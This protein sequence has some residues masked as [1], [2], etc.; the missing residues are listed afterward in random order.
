ML[1]PPIEEPNV[2]D[3]AV[4]KPLVLPSRVTGFLVFMFRVFL[5]PLVLSLTWISPVTLVRLPDRVIVLLLPWTFC[6]A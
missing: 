6:V 1:V 5:L 3:T 4:P 2:A